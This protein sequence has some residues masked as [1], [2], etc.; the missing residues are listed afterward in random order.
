[1]PTGVYSTRFLIWPSPPGTYSYTVPAAKR[2]VVT[3]LEANGGGTASPIL[4]VGIGGV[5]VMGWKLPATGLGQFQWDGKLVL[6]AGERLD[7]STSLA[8]TGMVS[9]YLFSDP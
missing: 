7:I 8:C 5:W 3:H 4:L 2:A 9:G 6:Y 1:M